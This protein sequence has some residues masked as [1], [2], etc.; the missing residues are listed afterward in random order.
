LNRRPA[1]FL[2]DKKHRKDGFEVERNF[3]AIKSRHDWKMPAKKISQVIVKA[4]LSLSCAS[5]MYEKIT[6]FTG[7]IV[8]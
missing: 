8:D 2:F 5:I 6:R 3:G 1:S 4:I 7:F